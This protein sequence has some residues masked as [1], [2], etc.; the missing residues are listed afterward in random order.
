M[1]LHNFQIRMFDTLS[2]IVYI[3][4]FLV[5]MGLSAK[6]PQYLADLQYYL[7]IY[8]SLFLIIRF[9]NF[10]HIEFTDLDRK[11]A[12]NAG[13][14]LFTAT[15]LNTIIQHYGQLNKFVDISMLN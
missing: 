7:K 5:V 2:I 1:N 8:I 10:R 3:L 11:I 12:F 4:Y 6:A 15:L 9:N 13:V 14:F